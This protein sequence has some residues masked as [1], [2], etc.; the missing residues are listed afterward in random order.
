MDFE[1][2][3]NKLMANVKKKYD[4]DEDIMQQEYSEFGYICRTR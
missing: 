3:G 4:V 1:F 2:Y